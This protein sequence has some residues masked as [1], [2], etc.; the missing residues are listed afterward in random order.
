VKADASNYA[1]LH[2]GDKKHVLRETTR[3]LEEQFSPEQFVR[4]SRSAIVNIERIKELQPVACGNIWW[5]ATHVED[6]SPEEQEKRWKE[7]HR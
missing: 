6:L 4:V 2:V 5:V 3:S 1:L 7:F